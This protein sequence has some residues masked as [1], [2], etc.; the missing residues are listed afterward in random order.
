MAR[1]ESVLTVFLASPGDVSEERGRVEEVFGEWNRTW[2]RNLGVRLELIRWEEDAYPGVGID[3]QDVINSQIPDNYD[4]FIGL[5]WSRFGTP[6]ARAA[7]G[8]AEEFQRALA[9]YRTSPDDLNIFF[10]FKDTPIPPSKLDPAQLL[11]IQQFKASL[12]KEGLLYWDFTDPDHFEKLI[13]LHITKHVQYWRKWKLIDLRKSPDSST[14]TP[15]LAKNVSGTE[16]KITAESAFDLDDEDAGYLDLLEIFTEKNIEIRA[17]ANRLSDAQA[18]LTARTT[19]GTED[20]K[21][22]STNPKTATPTHARR[23]IAKVADEMLSFTNRVNAEVPLFRE[24]VDISIRSLTRAA[25]LSIEV[26]PEDFR[27]AQNLLLAIA[28][29]RQSMVNFRETT[30]GLPR[31]TKE[32]NTAKRKQAEALSHLINE[33]ENAERLLTE[34]VAVIGRLTQPQSLTQ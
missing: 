28:G 16:S 32:L 30:I 19:Q 12:G 1:T 29:A 34:G 11:Q 14:G 13:A 8:T 9:R 26:N 24:A 4:L 21:N 3:A 31:I 18:D 10:Y 22:L 33:F 20:L 7:S 2:S 15:D 6:T 25:T 17:I 27:S 5:M 23:L